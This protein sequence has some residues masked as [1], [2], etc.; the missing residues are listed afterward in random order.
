[1]PPDVAAAP[2]VV[3]TLADDGDDPREAGDLARLAD[4]GAAV[5]A[6]SWYLPGG[7]RPARLS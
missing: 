3:V 2:A 4:R 5:A 7:S 1:V 6:A